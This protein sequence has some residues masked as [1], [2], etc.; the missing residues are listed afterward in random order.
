MNK[1]LNFVFVLA[2]GA[3]AEAQISATAYRVF[4]QSDLT[5]S[6][7][8]IVQGTELNAPSALTTDP[9]AGVTHIY[10]ADTDNSRVLGWT[11]VGSYQTGDPPAVVL[12]QP[13]PNYSNLQGIGTKGFN[14]PAGLAVDPATGNLY[15]ADLGNSRILR[16]PSPFSNPAMNAPD[17]V[18]GQPGFATG[19]AGLSNSALAQPRAIAF[20][21]AGNLWVA[22]TGNN[23]VLR[24]PSAVLDG[25]TSPEADL[26]V[27]QK[28]FT[29]SQA[30]QGGV[31][32]AVGLSSPDGIA[33]DSSNNLYVSDFSNGRV[34]KFSAPLSG[35]DAAVGV[36]GQASLTARVIQPASN[37]S[38]AGPAGLAVSPAGSLYVSVPTENRVMVFDA[39]STTAST[40][41]GQPTLTGS[42]SNSATYPL[43]SPNG[44]SSPS[45]V[46]VD[47]RGRVFIADSGNNRVVGFAAGS[48]SATEVWGQPNFTGVGRNQI[49]PASMAIP[50]SVAID[51]SESPYPIYVADTGNHRILI[52]KDSVQ[53]KTGDAADLVI[54]QPNLT[55]AIANVDTGSSLNPSATS[56]SSPQGIALD[57][58]GN[59]YVADS[60]NNR[61]LRY[62]RPVNQSGRITPNAVLGQSNFT[63]GAAAG[64]SASSFLSP[65]D[66]A[67]GPNGELFVADAGNNRVL[68]FL[69]NFT[70]GAPAIQVYGQPNFFSGATSSSISAQTLTA[71]SGI[72][73]DPSS[74]LYV[75]DSGNNRILIFANTQ[76]PHGNGLP[77]SV[78]FG[79][80]AF[81]FGAAGGGA[82]GLN[83]PLSVA[84]D[85]SGDIFVA[86]AGNNR[87]VEYPSL[88][89]AQPAGTAAFGV[90]GQ[91][92]LGANAPNW[93][94]PA[95][96]LATAD[97]LFAPLGVFVDREDT[98]Y[99]SD[100]GNHRV[101][102]FLRAAAIVN[103]A[104][105][106]P[107]APV[108]QGSMA[109]LFSSNICDQSGASTGL[110]L[111]KSLAAREIAVND[112]LM[113]PL[114]T[115]ATNQINFQVPAAALVGNNRIAVRS[116]ETGELIAGGT[117]LVSAAAP[118]L[119]T[120]SVNGAGQGVILNQNNTLNSASNPAALG[121]TVTLYGT[122]QGQVTP[123]VLDGQPA[124]SSPLSRTVTVAASDAQAC[125]SSQQS[126]CVIVGSNSFGQVEFSGLAPGFVG[127]WQMNVTI[128]GTAPA[129]AAV[130]LRVFIDGVPSNTVSI[131]LH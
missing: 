69:A 1:S 78:V 23:R 104:D 66:V 95:N 114:Y 107:T 75:A 111:P 117:F 71:P 54:G 13:G 44:L 120:T 108:A 5:Q 7:L 105:F 48:R 67:I 19:A 131:A 100:S 65:A 46:K 4:G 31:V 27:G 29:S 35:S 38:M 28:D 89:F 16:F 119:F 17:A 73:V 126:I 39:G 14:F 47:S 96:G 50:N 6:G 130:P 101:V 99:V 70:S 42:Q 92:N 45:D 123:P 26:V 62:P 18:I 10:I 56:L 103:A 74:N 85:S 112:S 59:L 88:L 80:P 11:D 40:V 127:L 49:K 64:V 98:L 8:N 34:V 121:S 61:V 22:D 53:Y 102:H 91:I 110:P 68:E 55:T 2:F 115:A 79:Q 84:L 86:D 109:T 52:W 82:G 83:V 124:P 81:D 97:S 118:G 41:F 30:N 113:A 36:F 116:S 93:D 77:A 51:Y 63:T 37:A 20:D 60:G 43:A 57:P 125:L 32:S 94:S 106:L 87:V 90:I 33:I 122:G 25:R 128:P 76:G 3:S 24:F 58:S 9:R 72:F 12:G 129:G 15:V 21:S